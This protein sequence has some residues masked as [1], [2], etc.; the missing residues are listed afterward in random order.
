LGDKGKKVNGVYTI[1]SCVMVDAMICPGA[2]LSN[3][4]PA[5]A[6]DGA[7][8]NATLTGANL[9]DANLMG[10]RMRNSNLAGAD[11]SGAELEG[12]DLTRANLSGADLSMANLNKANLHQANLIGTNLRYAS[13][14][15]ATLSQV[16]TDRTTTCPDGTPGPCT[17]GGWSA[18]AKH[19]GEIPAIEPCRVIHPGDR[20]GLG[21]SSPTRRGGLQR[22]QRHE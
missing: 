16:K 7:F 9:A 20:A 12:T 15:D 5:G 3:A 17:G 19:T 14:D 11:L 6:N 22:H 8:A 21:F 1:G 13:V 4:W 18:P 2:D 10:R